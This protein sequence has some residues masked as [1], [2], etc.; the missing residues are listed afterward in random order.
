MSYAERLLDAIKWEGVAGVSFLV[1]EKRGQTWYLETNG[2]F[3]ASDQGSIDVGW[4]FP[5]WALRYFLHGEVPT[6]P[7]IPSKPKITCYHTADLAALISFLRGG[8]S[9]VTYGEVGK[10]KA[11]WQYLRAF[12][13]G[14]R[15]DVFR[16]N[17]PMPAVKDHIRLVKMYWNGLVRRVF[18]R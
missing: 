5:Y 7:P 18:P 10:L 17:D 12:G 9:P 15:S 1:D 11:I 2:R 13:P 16:W 14:Y 8:P 6:P 3:W 4:D